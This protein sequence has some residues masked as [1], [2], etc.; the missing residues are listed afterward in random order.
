MTS[1]EWKVWGVL[2]Q[3]EPNAQWQPYQ[4]WDSTWSSYICALACKERAE[5]AGFYQAKV[6]AMTIEEAKANGWHVTP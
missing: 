1:C 5:A 3:R 4:G 6:V 2:I